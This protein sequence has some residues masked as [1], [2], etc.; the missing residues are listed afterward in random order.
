M[1]S[2]SLA[3]RLLALQLVILATALTVVA[4]STAW[5]TNRLLVGQERRALANVAA[6]SAASVTQEWKEEGGLALAAHATI[7]ENPFQDYRLDI[8]DEQR[9]PVASTAIHPGARTNANEMRQ[10]IHIPRGAWVVATV[11]TLPR[12]RAMTALLAALAL[13]CSSVFALTWVASRI[14]VAQ[15]LSPL[16]RIADQARRL[17]RDTRIHPLH[18]ESDPEE[19][20]AV[21]LAFDR[22]LARL[23]A[24]LEAE[25]DFTR[26]AAHELR[27]PLTIIRGELEYALADPTLLGPRRAHLSLARDQTRTLGELVDALLLLREVERTGNQRGARDRPVNLA[28]VVREL[29]TPLR[30][31]RPSRSADLEFRLP[32]EALVDGRVDLLT[33]A[34]RNL[35]DNALKFSVHRQP[36]RITIADGTERVA[37][38]VE[39]GGAGIPDEEAERVFD[40]FYR[41][42]EVRATHAGL[43]LGLSLARRIARAHGGDISVCHSELGGARFDLVLPAFESSGAV[44]CSP[45][46]APEVVAEDS[47]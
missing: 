27:T 40:P 15:A 9:R 41:N 29:A 31:E 16:A 28:D 33:A 43:G 1:R 36:V 22:T 34:T 4:L 24:L 47:A 37:L 30:A 17:A 6:S 32:D 25:R 45:A 3:T 11:S 14:L 13:V 8:L 38:I 26:D 19:V 46:V 10:A 7:D 12:R 44:G 2:R 39:D 42:A 20:A 5:L 18:E 23:D 21:S 35:I